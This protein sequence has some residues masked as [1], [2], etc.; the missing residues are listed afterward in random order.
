MRRQEIFVLAWNNRVNRSS[1]RFG[2][3]GDTNQ[4][5]TKGNAKGKTKYRKQILRVRFD[6]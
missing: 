2:Q 5:N 6:Q 4:D 1:M 3:E